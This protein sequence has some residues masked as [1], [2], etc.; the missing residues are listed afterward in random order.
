[1]TTLNQMSEK[2]GPESPF[3]EPTPAPGTT[4]REA[5]DEMVEAGLLDDLM[6][7]VDDGGLRL[8]GEGGFYRR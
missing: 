7:R 8:T 6:S 1:M 4:A 5:V 3:G 2:S